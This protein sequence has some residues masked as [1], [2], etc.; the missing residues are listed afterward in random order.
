MKLNMYETKKERLD[1]YNQ[2]LAMLRLSHGQSA[3]I[4]PEVDKF[5]NESYEKPTPLGVGWIAQCK[6]LCM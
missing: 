5:Y 4:D 6:S 2:S 3:T 1:R